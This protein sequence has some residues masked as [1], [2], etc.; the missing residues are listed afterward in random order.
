MFSGLGCGEASPHSAHHHR[1]SHR[2][3]SAAAGVPERGGCGRVRER[4]LLRA[5]PGPLSALPVHP[6]PKCTPSPL[7]QNIL[8]THRLSALSAS[9]GMA[10][11]PSTLLILPARPAPGA[12]S[13]PPSP[14]TAIPDTCSP[15][16]LTRPHA[17]PLR[18][19]PS[20]RNC[21]SSPRALLPGHLPRTP[22]PYTPL[23]APS[24]YL[25]LPPVHPPCT[26]LVLLARPVHPP[27]ASCSITPRTPFAG[28]P[29]REPSPLR[30]S[31]SA[32]VLLPAHPSQ[33]TAESPPQ[34]VTRKHGSRKRNPG[35]DH[36]P[37]QGTGRVYFGSGSA[38]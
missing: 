31:P 9:S 37:E 1:L 23:L 36:S 2:L 20:S 19:L 11:P 18:V 33:P 12:P 30:V 27:R 35:V 21:A 14:W 29:P 15:Q 6:V 28:H 7:S 24:P 16:P 17:R 26:L 38:R 32:L 22:S 10:H 5:P 25:S 13:P 8:P 4:I 34:Q 3:R